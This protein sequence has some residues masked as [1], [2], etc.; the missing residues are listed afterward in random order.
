MKLVKLYQ[1]IDG[2]DV[3]GG[4]GGN[5]DK[6]YVDSAGFTSAESEYDA[7]VTAYNSALDSII[8]QL[9]NLA[10]SGVWEG[11]T[12]STEWKTKLGTAQ[13]KLTTIG[14]NLK[15]NKKMFSAIGTYVSQYD[16]KMKNNVST[17]V[18]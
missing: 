11:G 2:A 8:T 17:M 15:Q 13:T 4:G 1:Y 7:A 10:S 16:T 3:G 6:Y 12:A 14:D 5:A 18:E 9:K